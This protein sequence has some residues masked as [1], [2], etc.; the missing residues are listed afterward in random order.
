MEKD[1]RQTIQLKISVVPELASAFKSACAAANA[2]MASVLSE[3]MASYSNIAVKKKSM[4]DYST[5]RQRRTA[6]H[7]II[8]KLEQ[9]HSCEEDCRDRIP[10]NLR[11][12]AVFDK[13]EDFLSCLEMALDA[14]GSIDS[15]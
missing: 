11:G 7:K 12:S 14:L 4:T 8:V 2:S 5:K 3:F 1:S 13:A 9:I 15:A 6:I 10:E